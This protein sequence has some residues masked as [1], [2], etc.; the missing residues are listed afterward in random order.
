M[1]IKTT[2]WVGLVVLLVT[3]LLGGLF[4][5]ALYPGR[6]SSAASSSRHR[7]VQRLAYAHLV[8]GVLAGFGIALLVWPIRRS[9]TADY[10]SS[11]FCDRRLE[12]CRAIGG[13]LNTE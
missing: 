10:Q 3:I 11:V 2:R 5:P 7:T 1:S 12:S 13:C 6:D 8:A 9:D 4:L